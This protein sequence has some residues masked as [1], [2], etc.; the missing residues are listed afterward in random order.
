MS[1]IINP[2]RFGI[3][4]ND[5][6][7]VLLLHGDGA[8]ASTTITDS[9]TGGATSPHTMTAV[10][11]VQI[12]TAQN[13]FGGASILYDGTGDS[14][15]A[16]DAADWSFFGADFTIDKWIR[17][18]AVPSSGNA[19]IFMCQSADA[20]NF[21]NFFFENAAGTHRLVLRQTDSSVSRASFHADITSLSADTWVHV[22][23]ERHGANCNFYVNG[24][25]QTT[26]TT[27]AFGTIG[28]ISAILEIGALGVTSFPF[29]GWMD[30][31]RISKGVA[32][33]AGVNFTPPVV[34]YS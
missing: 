15:S 2:F 30:E 25:K 14:V 21:W 31:V 29:A 26:T 19:A 9:S 16:A 5:A 20:N 28:N 1:F 23:V 12:D 34:A 32:R 13:K 27:T 10:G 17:F 18:S 8:D 6:F 11:N 7:T 24:T 33:Y 3:G 22:A 4:G